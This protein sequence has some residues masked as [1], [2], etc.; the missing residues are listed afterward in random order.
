MKDIS[1]NDASF[2][3]VDATQINDFRLGGHIIPT[4]NA[5]YDL[6]SAEYKIRHLFLSD[7]SLWL[8]DKHKI[9]VSGGKIRFK[10]R[11]LNE[12]PKVKK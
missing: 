4:S 3:I 7:N 5:T 9:D 10:K 12:I 1:G 11:Q 8:G 6:G 2:N